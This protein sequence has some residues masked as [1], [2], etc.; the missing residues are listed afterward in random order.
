MGGAVGWSIPSLGPGQSGLVQLVVHV[1]SPLPN[2]TPITNGSYSIDSNE[3]A[4]ATGPPVTTTVR[5]FVILAID[6]DVSTPTVID[7]SRALSGPVSSLDIGIV[8]DAR[9]TTGIGDVVRIPFGVINAF[10]TGGAVVTAITPLS[11]VDVMPPAT[12]PNNAT[13]SGPGAEFQFGNALTER[14]ATG[15]GFG[16][17]PVQ[18]ARFRIFFGSVPPSSSVR[19]FIGDAGPGS[20]RVR[21]ATGA[22][23]SGDATPDGTP[24]GGVPGADEGAAAGMDYR[25]GVIS[26]G[27]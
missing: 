26:F 24:V 2:G 4:P 22:D 1:A 16:G 14:G 23:I 7:S 11:I 3:T 10:N 20:F 25:D 19:I 15:S 18:Y 12:T 17:G 21:S 6:T 5:T 13:F 27:P 9:S 8:L